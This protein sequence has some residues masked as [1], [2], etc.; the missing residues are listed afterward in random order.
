VSK[1]SISSFR[2][3]D[4]GWRLEDAAMIVGATTLFSSFAVDRNALTPTITQNR[5]ANEL[6]K[7]RRRLRIEVNIIMGASP[8]APKVKVICVM[9]DTFHGHTYFRI[10]KAR[11][12]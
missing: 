8:Q 3:L 1:E 4:F 7:C 11:P 2:L 10:F 6:P 12:S 5:M 9:L